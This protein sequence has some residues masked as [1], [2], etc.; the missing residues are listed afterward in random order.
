MS[1]TV[2]PEPT[3][4]TMTAEQLYTLCKLMPSDVMLGT[5]RP[6]SPA[7]FEHGQIASALAFQLQL[8]VRQHNLGKVISGEVGIFIRRTP[9]TIRTTDVLFISHD[10]L[11]QMRSKAYLDVAPE[12]VVEVLAE[13]DSWMDMTEKLDEYFKIGVEQVWFANPRN[14]SLQV[15]RSVTE[16]A[17]FRLGDILADVSFLPTFQLKISEIYA[18]D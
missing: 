6:L 8:F 5:T 14:K 16:S 18:G 12:L 7:G 1:S 17:V 9:D 3:D 10:R 15:F 13:S 4:T 2:L 11:K